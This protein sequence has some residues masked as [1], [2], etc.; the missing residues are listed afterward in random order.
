MGSWLPFIIQFLPDIL[1]YT[2][3]DGALL[4]LIVNLILFVALSIFVARATISR[5]VPWASHR[6]M[7]LVMLGLGALIIWQLAIS[8]TVFEAFGVFEVEDDFRGFSAYFPVVIYGI[9]N[10]IM[11]IFVLLKRADMRRWFPA[12]VKKVRDA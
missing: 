8:S 2:D 5:R 7:F 4:G 12:K 11:L 3:A 1:E 10:L 9:G 6:N